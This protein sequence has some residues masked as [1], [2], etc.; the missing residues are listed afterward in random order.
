MTRCLA[1]DET[2]LTDGPLMAEGYGWAL[3][4]QT[5]LW[6]SFRC[7]AVSTGLPSQRIER[8]SG[9]HISP[10]VG[11]EC[12]NGIMGAVS[13]GPINFRCPYITD[14]HWQWELPGTLQPVPGPA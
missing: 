2:P 6:E 11:T 3:S 12:V 9:L 14:K 13:P 5:R 7:L 4:G 10:V 1:N 8:P